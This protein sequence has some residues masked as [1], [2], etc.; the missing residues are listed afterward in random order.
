MTNDG[1][2]IER[3][4]MQR[5]QTKCYSRRMYSKT[6][7]CVAPLNCAVHVCTVHA[8]QLKQANVY[9]RKNSYVVNHQQLKC[10]CRLAIHISIH[11]TRLHIRLYSLQLTYR[12]KVRPAPPSVRP[13]GRETSRETC[14]QATA[15]A[16]R[17]S[18]APPPG[19]APCINHILGIGA[20]TASAGSKSCELFS[21]SLIERARGVIVIGGMRGLRSGR[22]KPTE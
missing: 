17:R 6:Y 7:I 4:G 5:S 20:E 1:M 19:A 10:R 11:D 12:W 18:A 3:K 9:C 14:A 15:T 21:L 16:A 13:D 8:V 2:L 22:C